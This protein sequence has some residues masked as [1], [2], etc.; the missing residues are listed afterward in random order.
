MGRWILPR[1]ARTRR[2]PER[3]RVCIDAPRCPECRDDV[4]RSRDVPRE[5]PFPRDVQDGVTREGGHST[6]RQEPSTGTKVATQPLFHARRVML[7]EH[8]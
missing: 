3:I 8:D 7:E 5:V 6:V 4:A 1:C 2:G